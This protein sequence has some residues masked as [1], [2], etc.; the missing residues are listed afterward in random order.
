MSME[1]KK[2]I[3]K[4][5]IYSRMLEWKQNAEGKTALLIKGARR[6]GKSTIAREFARN[7]Y[8]TYIEI[9]FAK[10]SDEVRGLFDDVQDIDFL[11]FRLQ[12]IFNTT[13]STR[14]SVIILDEI[15]F[16][17]K[18]RQAIKYL[19]EDG[20]YDYIETGSLITIRKNTQ[21]ILIPSEET[22]L[23]MYPL[24]Y[25]E[26]LSAIGDTQTWPLLQYCYM[27]RKSIPDNQSRSLMR[28]FRLF[29][30]IGGMPQSI[31]EYMDTNDMARVDAVKRSIIE[32]YLDD[33]EKID[34][35]G[36]ISAIFKDIPSQ[37]SRSKL[38]FEMGS[39]DGGLRPGNSMPL[40]REM[41]E[42]MTVN[43]SYK[44]SDPNIGMGLHKD[45]SSF[46][47]Y[48]GDT[49]LF[50]TLAFWDSDQ[51]DNVIYS[52]LLSDKLS[53]DLGYVY[54]NVVSQI[55]KAGG[56]SLYYYTFPAR[57]DNKKH[58]EID[59]LLS[60]HDKLIPVEVKSSGYKTH[61]SLDVFCEKYS[62]RILHPVM[63][64]TKALRTEGN[65]LMIPAYLSPML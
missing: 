53:A 34:P 22:R 40:L 45:S 36:L 2:R 55:L 8:D 17:P 14:K 49:G 11:F 4:R 63:V 18:A 23:T 60:K 3:F 59:F 47:I 31:N 20:R 28:S 65:L 15:Q 44:C 58:Y 5:K 27:H 13:L 39:V 43:I 48:M 61:R 29:M 19:V 25:E 35:S 33:F 50:V 6:V 42:S 38:K 10:T 26:F 57:D 24:D 21:G 64:Y 41:E 54:E 9:D 37:L 16:C 46:K 30:L 7:E 62:D 32:L 51:A 12:Q 52:K 56:H 1:D